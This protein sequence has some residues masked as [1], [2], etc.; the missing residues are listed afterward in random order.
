MLDYHEYNTSGNG[1]QGNGNGYDQLD[2]DWA[3]YYK[4][5]KG[6]VRRVKL[7]DRQDFLHDLL[8][9]M[10]EVKAKYEVI[11]KPLTEGGLI[12]IACY[13]VAHYWREQFR[14]TNGVYCHN[15]SKAQRQKCR[16][17][18]L[19]RECPKAIKLVS[20]A[21]LIEDG[22]GGRTELCEMIADD[23]AVDIVARLDARNTLNG[24]PHRFV[25]IAYKK[26]AGYPLTNEERAYLYRQRR[27]AQKSLVLA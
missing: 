16:E 13:R 18:D 5:A 20:L 1:Y 8:L 26:Y 4:V 15:C 7:E 21:K 3:L 9:E 11:G 12:R 14:L 6:F 25:Q 17:K 19:Y 27:K 22:N 2:G 10:A 24:Y 23:N